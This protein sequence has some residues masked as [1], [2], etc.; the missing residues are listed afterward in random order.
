LGLLWR[1][2]KD[3]VCPVC[4]GVGY[5]ERHPDGPVWCSAARG[6]PAGHFEHLTGGVH[7]DG[8]SGA[9]PSVRRPWEADDEDKGRRR[10]LVSSR[11]S[12]EARRAF[13]VAKAGEVDPPELAEAL[14]ALG[15]PLKLLPRTGVPRSIRWLPEAVRCRRAPSEPTGWVQ[16]A[17]GPALAFLMVDQGERISAVRTLHLE[18]PPE[19]GEGGEDRRGAAWRVSSA[20]DERL[21]AGYDG[22]DVGI[23]P[24]FSAD[25]AGK[26]PAGVLQLSVD[27]LTAVLAWLVTGYTTWLCGSELGAVAAPIPATAPARGGPRGS[28]EPPVKLAQFIAPGPDVQPLRE[29]LGELAAAAPASLELRLNYPAVPHPDWLT[30]LRVEKAPAVLELLCNPEVV[31]PVGGPRAR[32]EERR[33]PADGGVDDEEIISENQQERGRLALM[34]LFAPERPGPTSGFWLRRVESEWFRHDGRRYE[35]LPDEAL[36]KV[37]RP[38]LNRF[39]HRKHGELQPLN[40]GEKTFVEL[41]ANMASEAYVR[42]DCIPC[43]LEADFDREGKPRW[44]EVAPWLTAM[45]E[46]R[47]RAAQRPDPRELIVFKNGMLDVRAWLEGSARLLPHTELFFTCTALPYD[48]PL[49]EVQTIG[50]DDEELDNY[51]ARL[52]PTWCE[53]LDVVSVGNVPN[54]SSEQLRQ[55]YEWKRLLAKAMGYTLVPW[56]NHEIVLVLSGASR[57]GKGTILN[58]WTSLLGDENVASTDINLLTKP[59]SPWHWLGKSLLVMPDADVGKSTDA[60]LATEMLKKIS[61]GDPVFADRKH[62]EALPAVRLSCKIAIMCNRMPSLPDPSGALANRFR[63]LQFEESAAGRERPEFKDPEVMKR[64]ATGRMLWALRGLRWLHEDGKFQQPERG[65]ELLQEYRD[66]SDP[67]GTFRDEVFEFDE[68]GVYRESKEYTSALYEAWKRFCERTGRGN[69][70]GD[71]WFAKELRAACPWI[72]KV[73]DGEGRRLYVGLKLKIEWRM[74]RGDTAPIGFED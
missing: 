40:P 6:S 44:G 74:G 35:K 58:A 28:A 60:L 12:A 72:R 33:D 34:E 9:S 22:G 61:G 59:F 57:A 2:L 32:A 4:G 25:G 51:I 73:Q 39:W 31:E 37:L 55:G 18:A 36:R 15:L 45:D 10:G 41:E 30:M 46:D 63:V 14:S 56:V 62:K 16:D 29:A 21:W 24:G 54:P 48:F 69:P 20:Q 49:R 27:P 1:L 47:R 50:D 26:F 42:A 67:L 5:C 3:G 68:Q 23:L 8:A 38:W 19:Q 7:I 64:E 13:K 71:A 53:F 43:W 70:H 11:A 52:C 65:A 17:P 66:Y